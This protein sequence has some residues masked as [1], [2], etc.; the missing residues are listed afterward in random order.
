MQRAD[1]VQ[2]IGKI[3]SIVPVKPA[4]PILA[5]IL[6]EA[7]NDQLIISATDLTVSMRVSGM[8]KVLESGSITLPAKHLFQLVR[9][10]TTPE[11]MIETLSPEVAVIHAGT[12][13][14]RIQGMHASEFPAL[15]DLSEGYQLTFKSDSLK[16]MLMRTAFAAARDDS[17]QVLNGVLLQK[18]NHL[19]TFIGTDGRRLARN[20]MEIETDSPGA[21]NYILPIK[22]V[23]EIVKMNDGESAKLILMPEK[24]AIETDSTV[25]ITKLIAGQYP[26]VTRVIPQKTENTVTLHREELITL[27][28]QV[29]LFTEDRE[30]VRFSFTEGALHLTASKSSIGEG[31]VCMP[32]N[33]TGPK[34]EIA[35]NPRSFLDILRHIKDETVQFEVSDSYNPGLVTD[36]SKAEFVIMPM[37]LEN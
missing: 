15:P 35:F 1:F 29:S 22:A 5:N 25:L 7:E 4:I 17:R 26:D 11:I 23:E 13:N 31:K 28:R 6:I 2:L 16:E 34:L 3:Q 19:T 36:S 20:R 32:V 9:E 8:A 33:Y 21:G 18:V 30:S 14:F 12:S 37:R 10:L 24:L 27:L